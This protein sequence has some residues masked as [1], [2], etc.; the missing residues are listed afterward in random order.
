MKQ[1]FLELKQ[2]RVRITA[3]SLAPPILT[4]VVEDDEWR[5]EEEYS[6]RFDATTITVEEGYR[7]DL[8]SVPRPFWFL[9]APFELSITAPLIHDFLYEHRGDPP[10]GAIDPP[11]RFSRRESDVV[12]KKIMEEE[13]VVRWRRQAAYLAVRGFAWLFWRT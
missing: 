1:E 11:R 13:G 9:I 12:F 3:S 2:D 6:Y 4:R 10:A 8:A 5:L 7:F